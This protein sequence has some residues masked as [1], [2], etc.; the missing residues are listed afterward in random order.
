MSPAEQKKY[1]VKRFCSAL[2]VSHQSVGAFMS[3]P[4]QSRKSGGRSHTVLE[5]CLLLMFWWG[6]KT[7]RVHRERL[8]FVPVQ[9]SQAHVKELEFCI[10]K[11]P[12]SFGLCFLTLDFVPYF[13][14]HC[15]QRSVQGG[16]K[17][18]LSVFIF[19]LLWI[20]WRLSFTYRI[21]ISFTVKV[22]ATMCRILM[23]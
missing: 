3:S 2:D 9:S 7:H 15:S 22:T 20:T 13:L 17:E 14:L 11:T 4:L 1:R 8:R 19:T 23:W 5:D 21:R 10:L 18:S 16:L 12:A 6:K